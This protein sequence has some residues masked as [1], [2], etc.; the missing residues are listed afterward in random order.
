[1]PNQKPL[2]TRTTLVT[3]MLQRGC[4]GGLNCGLREVTKLCPPS[5]CRQPLGWLY[6]FLRKKI[7]QKI[8]ED[9]ERRNSDHKA[10]ARARKSRGA[11][12][13]LSC[14]EIRFDQ[15]FYTQVIFSIQT[16]STLQWLR[17][18]QIWP[19]F[20]E[21]LFHSKFSDPTMVSTKVDLTKL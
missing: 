5:W 3:V 12:I 21:V 20:L 11:S 6:E 15:T 10:N 17:R 7:V 13:F 18:R 8:P 9:S 1:M 19:N 4:R 16:F 14:D 2:A